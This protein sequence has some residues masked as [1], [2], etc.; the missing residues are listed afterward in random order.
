MTGEMMLAA[1]YHGNRDLRVE[2]VPVP[3]PRDD[4]LLLSVHATGLCGTDAAEWQRGPRVYASPCGAPHPVTGHRGP[5]IPGHELAG[6]VVGRGRGVRG[7]PDGMLVA[8]GAGFV[9]GEDRMTRAGRPHL[10]RRYAT[11]GL[12]ANGGFAQYCAVP[13]R[14]CLPVEGLHP[15]AAAL[16]QPM[17]IAVHAV[18]RGRLRA[19][20]RAVVMGAGGIGAFAVA[21]A[22]G[23]GA[24]VVAV[25][26]DPARLEVARRLGA[27]EAVTPDDVGPV[28]GAEGGGDPADVVIE[29]TGSASAWE[30]VAAKAP[31]GCRVVIAGLQAGPRPVDLR[32]LSQREH[33]LIGT[34]AHHCELDLPEAL[35]LLGRRREG[36]GDVAPVAVPLSEIVSGALLPLVERRATAIKT[37]VDPWTAASRPTDTRLRD[38]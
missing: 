8:C 31:A 36:W 24:S 2:Q 35:R 9:V 37:L 23:V 12:Q 25:D 17:A 22:V 15:D 11:V 13:A 30:L 32:A 4:E 16:A 28:L 38:A 19:G 29:A 26:L 10:S 6:H 1:V 5:L 21:A 18:R 7:F 27:A 14:A 3:T 20:E 33:E 34:N